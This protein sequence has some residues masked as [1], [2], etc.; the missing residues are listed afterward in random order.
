MQTIY[1]KAIAGVN[2]LVS[3]LVLLLLSG[4]TIIDKEQYSLEGNTE[5]QYSKLQLVIELDNAADTAALSE[6]L[7]R[8]LSR[9][10]VQLVE[11]R[12]TAD[13]PRQDQP[14]TG[15]LRIKELDRRMITV[16]YRRNY[17]RPA[18]T[19]NRGY[20]YTQSP[21]ITVHAAMFDGA[22]DRI[23][24]ESEYVFRAPWYSE[25]TAAMETI[26]GKII[27]ELEEKNFIVARQ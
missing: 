6:G 25:T 8:R 9:H 24:Y 27:K 26:A 17:S 12:Y 16:R 4:C 18:L 10:N 15:V 7:V 19:Q 2:W 21:Q 11:S 5:K 20:K 22:S 1:S 23:L 14:E 3:Y 13:S